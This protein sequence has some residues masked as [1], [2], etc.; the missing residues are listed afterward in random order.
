MYP[1]AYVVVEAE[2]K[3]S[4]IWFLETLVSDIGHHK[5]HS[6]PTFISDRQK[7]SYGT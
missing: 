4:W 3:D 7:V 6:M 2:I 1:I 5:R